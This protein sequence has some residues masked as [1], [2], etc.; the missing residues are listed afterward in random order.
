MIKIKD[1]VD[2]KELNKYPFES[3]D[4]I[5]IFW[6]NQDCSKRIIVYFSNREIY[7]DDPNNRILKML[8]R[9]GLVEEVK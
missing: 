5:S 8:K 2:L 3:S 9:D 4:D 7:C 1:S 6:V